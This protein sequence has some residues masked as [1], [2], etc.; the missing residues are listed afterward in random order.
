MKQHLTSQQ[1]INYKSNLSKLNFIQIFCWIGDCTPNL[2]IHEKPE[3]LFKLKIF[4][5]NTWIK[6]Q[7]KFFIKIF[8]IFKLKKKIHTIKNSNVN[9]N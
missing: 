1:I 4:F 3:T 6:L 5:P 2:K 7:K 9:S 8:K